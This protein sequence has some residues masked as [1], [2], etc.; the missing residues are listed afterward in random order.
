MIGQEFSGMGRRK[1][2][3]IFLI[4]NITISELYKKSEEKVGSVAK[5]VEQRPQHAQV[6]L[7]E[8]PG[9]RL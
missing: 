4:R 2:T 6:H 7:G 8:G 1:I 9:N 5:D 3:H